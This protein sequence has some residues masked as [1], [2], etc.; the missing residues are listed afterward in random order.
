[1]SGFSEVRRPNRL[2]RRLFSFDLR[3]SPPVGFVGVGGNSSLLLWLSTI[4]DGDCEWSSPSKLVKLSRRLNEGFIRAP[5][6]VMLWPKLS[7]DN[8]RAWALN[9]VL[10]VPNSWCTPAPVDMVLRRKGLAASGGKDAL[11]E[12]VSGMV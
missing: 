5:K 1:M 2:L 3:P 4:C 8:F 6:A 12:G 11:F 7:I 9:G 10:G